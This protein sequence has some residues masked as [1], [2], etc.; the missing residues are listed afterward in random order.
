MMRGNAGMGIWWLGMGL[1]WV[2][3]VALIVWLVVLL[4]RPRR[5][6]APGAQ[7]GG[8]P[9]VV[10]MTPVTAV[11]PVAPMAP[12]A[13]VPAAAPL[14]PFV[15]AFLILDRRLALG[16]IDLPTY[17]QLRAALVESRGGRAGGGAG[18]AAV[19][20]GGVPGGAR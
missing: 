16:E 2:V 19:P 1:F 3:L 14:S 18:G 13:A 11:A 12:A 15:E 7:S 20:D 8:Q 6:A 17:H 10:P 9:G 4:V 5:G